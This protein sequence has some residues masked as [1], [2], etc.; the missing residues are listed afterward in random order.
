VQ[1]IEQPKQKYRTFKE[2]ADEKE[3]RKNY[4]RNMID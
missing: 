3:K 1:K 2:T 4:F